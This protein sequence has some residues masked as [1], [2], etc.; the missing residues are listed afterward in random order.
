MAAVTSTPASAASAWTRLFGDHILKGGPGDD[1]KDGVVERQEAEVSPAVGND[2][3][4]N[5]AGDDRNRERQEEEGQE[6]LA[7]PARRGHRGEE[8]PHRGDAE[9]GEDDPGDRGAVD[10]GE[11]DRERRQRDDLGDGEERKRRDRLGEPDRAAVAGGEQQPVEQALLALG[12]EGSGEAEQGGEDDRHPE[13]AL[14]GELGALGGEGE[15]EDDERG[16]HEEEHRGNGVARAELEDEVLPRQDRD[17]SRVVLHAMA[18]RAEAR[19]ARRSGSWVAT[20]KVR[21]G[22]RSASSRSSSSAP[23]TSSAL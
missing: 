11:E 7:R 22:R 18:S 20:T 19:G 8:R 15:V 9:V 3:R 2:A 5:A 14:G 10:P 12:G 1:R 17:V 13:Q 6:Q 23:S 16:E 4:P 21:P